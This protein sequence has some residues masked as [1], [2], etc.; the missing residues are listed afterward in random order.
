MKKYTRLYIQQNLSQ[1]LNI[2]LNRQQSHYISNV[3]HLVKHNYILLFNGQDGEWLGEII[4]IS[5]HKL[6]SISLKHNTQPQYEE[7]KIYLYCAIVKNTALNNIVRQATEMG[8]TSIQF[9]WTE[10]TIMK[11]LNLNRI[12]SQVIAAS[13]QSGRMSI[14]N[15]Y[16]PIDFYDLHDHHNRYFYLCDYTMSCLDIKTEIQYNKNIAI[17]IGPEGGFSSS[18]LS[19]A[20]KFCQKLN[21]GRR[22]LRVDTAVIAALSLVNYEYI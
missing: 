15:I 12:I 6:V 1:G 22:I 13:A 8:V 5:S 2:E 9:L 16:S 21:L 19:F 18:E 17:I 20:S 7:K 10:R 11:T 14:P 3:I 4:H